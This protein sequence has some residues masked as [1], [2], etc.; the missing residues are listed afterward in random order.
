[1]I[2]TSS[3]RI[4]W[5]NLGR[6]R[7][8]TALTLAAIAIA[9]T[10]VLQMDGL[11]NAIMDSTLES[12]TG[13]LMGHAQLHDPAYREERAPDLTIDGVEA[14]LAALR[15]AP[16]VESA[17]ARVYAPALV[18]REVDGYAAMVVGVD[19]ARE[20]AVG[21]LLEGLPADARPG[22]RRALVGQSLAREA[23]IEVGDEL[24]VLGTAADG[25]MAN[26]LLTVVGILHTPVD[27]INR[28]GVVVPLETAQDLFVME[29]QAHEIT[30]V[31]TGTPTD[32]PALAARIAALDEAEG[33]EVLPWQELAPEMAQMFQ[34]TGYYGLIV[35]IIVF[36]AAAAGVANTMLMATFERR[37]ELGMLLSLGTSPGRLVRIVLIEAVILG[38]L[39]VLLGTLLGG[40]LVLYQGQVGLD[41]TN[42]GGG[43]R[44]GVDIAVY[45]VSFSH[46]VFPYL[47]PLDVVPGV[48]GVLV[49]SILAALGPA[50]QI[51]RL[52]P[53]AAMRGTA[54]AAG[55]AVK[56]GSSA[57]FGSVASRYAVRS[58][59]RNLR[60]TLLSVAGV[61]FG[62]G[63][64]ILA[65]SAVQGLQRMTI[66]AA[67]T[68]GIGHLRVTPAGW[69]ESRDAALRL[70]SGLA[71]LEALR[72]T[73]G[74]EV[75]TPRAR[76]GGLLGLGTR[77]AFVQLT[78]VD[79]VTEPLAL[80]PVREVRDGRYLEPGEEGALVLGAAPARRLGA[81]I[82]DELVVTVVDDDG[83][84][85]SRL[86][87]L[88]GVVATGSTAVD[89]TIAHVALSDVEALSG[90]EGPAE[91][92]IRLT[93]PDAM[94]QVGAAI[95]PRLSGSDVVLGWDRVSPELSQNMRSKGSFYNF[96]VMV[97]LLVVLLG[98][99]SAQLTGVLE[100]RKEFAVLAALGMRGRT[101]VRVVL[102]EGFFL[103]IGAALGALIWATPLAH[104]GHTVGIDIREMMQSQEGV[105]LGGV[106]FD[107]V[108]KT[109][110]GWWI[111]PAALALALVATLVA[112]LYPAWYATKTDPA[113]ALRVDR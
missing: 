31:G 72:A 111:L 76:V 12:V 43:G 14:R 18:A 98:V 105:A 74:V 9:Q 8:R 10:A 96:A 81:V 22:E 50:L 38:L 13:P 39:G 26:D 54:D 29:D 58:L 71:P 19:V 85:Q 42:L 56:A 3:L 78:G 66:D 15:A 65:I 88:V 49:V 106:L 46:A 24:A 82:G 70:E 52:E 59:R 61:A 41:V 36:I 69:E 60:R 6:N 64:G 101:L 87:E 112:S 94:A 84:M 51:A 86:L 99:A 47:S 83:E 21:G 97:I 16:E 110:F 91:I 34:I 109:G 102:S 92:T 53:V 57:L 63:M 27:L 25:S 89:E 103:G 5:R 77:S 90:R 7:R 28:T 1:M 20:A 80:R 100:R 75:A 40:G 48:L 32:A 108:I 113:A 33:L 44:E 23:G 73:E 45:G 107:P 93:D 2:G 95:E 30:V 62:V 67:A 68:G 11:M 35:M 79:P 4:A 104:R 37:R 55:S 17:Y